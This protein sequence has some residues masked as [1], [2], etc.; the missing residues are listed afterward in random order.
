MIYT[1]IRFLISYIPY[2]PSFQKIR[3]WFYNRIE[4][5]RRHY[6]KFTRRWAAR[7]VFYQLHRDEIMERTKDV[8]GLE[9]GHPKYLGALQDA[10]TFL[11]KD[12]STKDREEYV[13]AAKEWSTKTPPKDIQSR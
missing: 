2:H 13:K 8:S 7:S 11:W 12:L 1:C 3:K 9:A 5:P 10:T 4:S 6:T